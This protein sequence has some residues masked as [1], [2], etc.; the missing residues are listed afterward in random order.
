MSTVTVAH[1]QVSVNTPSVIGGTTLSD[2][3]VTIEAS[4]DPLLRHWARVVAGYVAP[5]GCDY[6][7]VLRGARIVSEDRVHPHPEYGPEWYE[8]EGDHGQTYQVNVPATTNYRNPDPCCNCPDWTIQRNKA[9]YAGGPRRPIWCKHCIAAAY[10]AHRF[11]SSRRMH[12]MDD[13][14]SYATMFPNGLYR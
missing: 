11:S 4:L 13:W 8:V 9:L 2:E 5:H 12:W 6:A 1:P 7:R 10:K 3:L 14:D